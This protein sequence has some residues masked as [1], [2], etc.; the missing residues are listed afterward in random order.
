MFAC[1]KQLLSSFSFFV[2]FSSVSPS[3]FRHIFFLHMNL[4]GYHHMC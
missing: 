3:K 2:I 1:V 4:E